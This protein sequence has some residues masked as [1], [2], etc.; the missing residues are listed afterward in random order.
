[1]RALIWAGLFGL[2]VSYALVPASAEPAVAKAKPQKD[3]NEI[4]CE[5]QEVLGSRLA[6]RRVCQTRAQ[7]AEQRRAERDLV[8][9]SQLNGRQKQC[10][11]KGC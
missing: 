7:W 2:S 6:V 9:A 8:H 4:V 3:M 5:K 10:S 1:M 11:T